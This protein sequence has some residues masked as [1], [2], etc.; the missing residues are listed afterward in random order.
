MAGRGSQGG[1]SLR[2]GGVGSEAASCRHAH[3]EVKDRM[4]LGK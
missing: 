3:R 4:G 1:R 2:A